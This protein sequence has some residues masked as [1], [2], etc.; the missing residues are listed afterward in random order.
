MAD[1]TTRKIIPETVSK[2]REGTTEK[3]RWKLRED[4]D[5]I[6]LMAMRKEPDRRYPS[7]EQYEEAQQWL[8][9]LTPH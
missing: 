6:V 8:L 2:T 9:A 3:L 5:N 1:G 7:A 4:L